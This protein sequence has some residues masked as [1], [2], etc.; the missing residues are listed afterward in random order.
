MHTH[1]LSFYY[2]EKQ[3]AHCCSCCSTCSLASMRTVKAEF[4]K[5]R[6]QSTGQKSTCSEQPLKNQ[7]QAQ[8]TSQ[9]QVL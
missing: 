9:V 2:K 7:K 5:L 4:L 1:A 6:C 3:A 8:I